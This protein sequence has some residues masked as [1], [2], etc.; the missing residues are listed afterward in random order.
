MINVGDAVP[1]YQLTTDQGE[2]IAL[3]DYS[4]KFV[5]LY[6]YPK[7]HTPGCTTQACSFRDSYDQFEEL[8]VTII[9][10]SPDS[11]ESHQSFKEKHDLPFS[12]IVDTDHQ[13]AK[14]FGATKMKEKAG[15]QYLGI[16]RSTYLIDQNGIVQKIFKDV[17]VIGHTKEVLQAIKEITVE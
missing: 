4:G 15:E 11:V 12:L 10:V 3:T 16:N 14:D 17:R 2:T 5:V 7:D 13:L 6:F 1:T 9:G 8:N